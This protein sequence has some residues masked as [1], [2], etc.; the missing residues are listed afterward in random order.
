MSMYADI[1]EDVK[2]NESIL[3]S[4]DRIYRTDDAAIFAGFVNNTNEFS[5]KSKD[6]DKWLLPSESYFRIDFSL[7]ANDPAN[8]P[9][10]WE[11]MPVGQFTT[12]I[13]G[14]L[15]LFSETRLLVDNNL[16]E[17]VQNPGY[18]QLIESL[19]TTTK[20]SIDTVAKNEWMYLDTGSV[21]I[22]SYTIGVNTPV[23]ASVQQ[24][25]ATGAAV[26]EVY[27]CADP[28]M[29][30]ASSAAGGF[31]IG[32]RNP[33]FNKGFYARWVLTN[34]GRK[35]ELAIPA[36]SVFG[37]FCDIRSAFRG[38]QFEVEFTKNTRYTEILHSMGAYTTATPANI[39]PPWDAQTLIQRI[40][41]IV[42]T[43]VSSVIEQGKA[44]KLL[45]S[46]KR[47]HKVF[48]SSTCYIAERAYGLDAPNPVDI[49]YRIQSTGKK[50]TR[51]AIAFQ[52]NAQF[53]VQHDPNFTA[54]TDTHSNGGVF[55]K[56][57]DI[58][59]V[60]LRYG[61]KIIPN[62]RY[63]RMSFNHNAINGATFMRNYIDFADANG[64][65]TSDAGV[66]IG[67]EEF[68]NLYPCFVFDLSE[69]DLTGSGVTS[70]DL[71]VVATIVPPAGAVA[72]DKYRILAV[73]S[74]EY[75]IVFTG[76]DG[77]LAIEL[78]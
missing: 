44:Q 65:W 7:V 46:G 63:N 50:I 38:V 17:Y 36:G 5:V 41:W 10:I 1:L 28:I 54:D 6:F 25:T 51:V 26:Q 57:G 64:G 9:P 14:G 16:I 45:E 72:A 2:K 78:P 23:P 35:V 4:P 11:K 43:V 20:D 37:F 8:V 68:R 39:D 70:E 74:Y 59:A 55:S 22:G 48:G 21:T 58:T 56:L 71:R 49:D 47:A 15:H 19:L 33:K 29:F 24:C 30:A 77:R 60:E 75:P 32:G 76:V 62:E 66:L 34:G 69:I 40:E 53:A 12:L 73:V 18:C 3:E 31:D 67:P 13:A 61:S 27:G 52:R 42:P